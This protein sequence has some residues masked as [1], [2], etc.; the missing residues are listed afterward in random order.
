LANKTVILADDNL[1]HVR[2]IQKNLVRSSFEG[3]ITITNNGQEVLDALKTLDPLSYKD[4][5]L[6]LDLNMPILS[7]IRVLEELKSNSE[8]KS[9]P[10]IIMTTT[11]DSKEISRCYALN[12]N[13]CVT[14]P[15]DYSEFKRVIQAVGE[16]ISITH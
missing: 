16:F 11:D 12:A 9:I 13:W 14:K 5:V 7:G 6:I 10:V 15:V 1:G 8:T 3:E 4:L 2:L